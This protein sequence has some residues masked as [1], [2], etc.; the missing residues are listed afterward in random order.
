MQ[1]VYNMYNIFIIAGTR[2]SPPLPCRRNNHPQLSNRLDA[3]AQCKSISHDR[4][5]GIDVRQVWGEI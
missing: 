5:D 4:S 3:P 1:C 2:A